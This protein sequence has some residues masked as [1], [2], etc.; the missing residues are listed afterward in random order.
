MRTTLNIDDQT[1][2]VVQSLAQAN[3][4]TVSATVQDLLR[5]ALRGQQAS[6]VNDLACDP[7]TGFPVLD[8]RRTITEND[9]RELLED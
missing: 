9:V 5:C 6:K 1:Y 8:S 2:T 7:L 4:K 3:Q